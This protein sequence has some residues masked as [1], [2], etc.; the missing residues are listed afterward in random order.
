MKPLIQTPSASVAIALPKPA[1]RRCYAY[2]KL[3]W[4]TKH[5]FPEK[6]FEKLCHTNHYNRW[7]NCK[8]FE[9]THAINLGISG[10]HVENVLWTAQDISLQHA[11]LFEII[12]CGI[13][14]VDQN[15]P[16]DIAAG[17]IKIVKTFR[18]K[19]PKLNNISRA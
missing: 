18:K 6:T 11:T 1:D 5:T 17:T 12:H 8:G 3:G 4:Q 19:H 13:N 2:T 15:Q 10:D 16:E 7:L 9:K 14:N